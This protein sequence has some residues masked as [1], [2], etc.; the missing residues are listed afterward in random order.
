MS[1][2]TRSPQRNL[3]MR[4]LLRAWLPVV[5]VMCCGCG[6]PAGPE[7]VRVTGTVKRGG[8]P[9]ESLLV[10][11]E[12]AS[13]KPSV[14]KTDSAGKFSLSLGSDKQGAVVAKHKVYFQFVAP[15]PQDEMAYQQGTLKV[16][17]DV[18][19][20][21]TKYGTSESSPLLA[22]VTSKDPQEIALVLE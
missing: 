20:A 22:E 13:G 17:E 3:L 12:P 2:Q 4:N 15:T 8:R 10:Y 9:I 6:G 11:F 19:V 7:V 16:S 14:G 1:N 21:T 5:L 18:M